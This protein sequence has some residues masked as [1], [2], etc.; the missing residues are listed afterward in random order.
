[1]NYRHAFHAGNHAD[2]FKH[3]VWLSLLDALQRKPGGMFVLD[4]HAGA[5]CY[6]LDGEEAGKTGEWHSG[7]GLLQL[8]TPTHPAL[9]RHVDLVAADLASHTYPGS[10]LLTARCLR[11]QD[12]LAACDIQ[13]DE[14][15]T[16]RQVLRPFRATVHA[17]SGYEAIKALLPPSE[18]RGAVLIDPPFEAQRA[19]F[20]AAFAA[21]QTGLS[22]WPQASWALWYPIKQSA[23]LRPVWRAATTLPARTMLRIEL[24]V[25]P[26]DSPLRLNGSGMLVLNPPWQWAESIAEGMPELVHA[27]DQGQGTWRLEW[28]KREAQ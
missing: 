9:R 24:L 8:R 2:V 10:P 14:V 6:R 13:D 3:I 15:G 25:R 12:R 23:S 27:L 4:T 5:G 1:M 22:R 21:I 19:E 26:D 11:E 28:M 7:I 18:R 20:D 17:R 16:L